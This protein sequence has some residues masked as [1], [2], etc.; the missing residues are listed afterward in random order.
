MGNSP[1][2]NNIEKEGNKI[3]FKRTDNSTAGEVDFNPISISTATVD[4]SGKLFISKTDGSIS[5]PFN[6][7]GQQGVGIESG[8]VDADGNLLLKLTDTTSMG[9][10]NI[11]GPKGDQGVGISKTE[12]DESGYL[13]ISTTDGKTE[14]YN[15]KGNDGVGSKGEPGPIGPTGPPGPIGVGEI[16]PV[17]QTGSKGD[18]GPIGPVGPGG[19]TGVGIS[20]A[21]MDNLGNVT[22]N[23]TDNTRL[24]TFQLRGPRGF[25]INSG[26]IED[27]SLTLNREDG[28][29]IGPFKVAGERGPV[30]TGIENTSYDEKTGLLSVKLT[31][32]LTTNYNVKPRDGISISDLNIDANGILRI[33]TS[34]GKSVSYNVKPV[35]GTNGS[36]GANGA[37]GVGISDAYME[38]SRLMLK[39]T[40][41]SVLGPFSVRGVDGVSGVGI[42]S[43]NMDSSGNLRINL[44]DGK[45][46]GPFNIRG[47]AGSN[48]NNGAPGAPGVGIESTSINSSGQLVIRLSNGNSLPGLNVKGN[49]GDKGADGVGIKEARIV[50]DNLVLDYTNGTS[51]RNFF[52][53]GPTGIQG[54]EGPRGTAG[55]T[56]AIGNGIKDMKLQ[57]DNVVVEYTDNSTKSYFNLRGPQ[58]TGINTAIVDS[59]GNLIIT[60]TNGK[61]ISNSG[62]NIKGPKGD[63]GQKGDNVT[64]RAFTS[65]SLNGWNLNTN[66][67]QLTFKRGNSTAMVKGYSP[68]VSSWGVNTP[69]ITN[70]EE[71]R[72]IAQ[73][74]GA[75]AFG[76]RNNTHPDQQYRNTCWTYDVNGPFNGVSNDNV[77]ITGCTNPNLS[78]LDGCVPGTA[79]TQFA[80][81]DK[82]INIGNWTL[83]EN[84]EGNLV[85]QKGDRTGIEIKPDGDINI[86]RVAPKW[87]GDVVKDINSEGVATPQFKIQGR[88]GT[89]HVFWGDNLTNMWN[90]TQ[91]FDERGFINGGR[92]G[93]WFG[94]NTLSDMY[95]NVNNSVKTN[96]TYRIWNQ[97]QGRVLALWNG[98]VSS[99]PHDRNGA[100]EQL[101]IVK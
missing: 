77:H 17:G 36:P 29:K 50:G 30:G 43:V 42:S 73:Q 68:N 13:L 6:V 91:H 97:N 40:D 41:N 62:A 65:L 89:G 72:I 39:L 61:V 48:G 11:K 74:S 15:V 44:S 45:G 81:G 58:G 95:D 37:P 82:S 21:T 8:T 46:A 9:P 20:T 99:N 98:G 33:S 24:G 84:S 80:I 60:D 25:S 35:N 86:N 31:N 1:S 55:N 18:T 52:V 14:K 32:G 3:V 96:E 51:S 63:P 26:I 12:F 4:D 23:K 2:I 56:G 71:C 79:P 78:M 88:P 49:T 57:G 66:A 22:I 47:Q 69:N 83:M 92:N 27:G 16:G 38:N 64:D 100:F 7:K 53:R 54:P 90:K 70:P 94:G 28:L 87:L 59:A 85:V 67:G 5:G 101:K 75:N 34:D 76:H 19:P 10:F 93:Y